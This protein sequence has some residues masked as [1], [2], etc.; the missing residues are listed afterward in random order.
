ME[1]ESVYLVNSGK[2][3]NEQHSYFPALGIISLGTAVQKY[4]PDIEL[5]VTDAQV[6]PLNE[7]KSS[8]KRK[9]PD[10]IGISVM[11]RGYENALKLVKE[12]K[13]INSEVILGNSYAASMGENILRNRPEVDYISTSSVGE[14]SFLGFLDY[15]EGRKNV[16]EVPKLLYRKNGKINHNP[17]TAFSWNDRWTALD[18]LPTPNRSLLSEREWDVFL[19]N[20]I[21]CY[22]R[23][24]DGPV[25]GVTTINRAK[26]CPNY[27]RRC[28]F[29][30]IEDLTL[31]FSSPEKFWEDVKRAKKQV[32]ANV[33]FE[34]CDGISSSSNWL[35]QVT[36]A[37]PEELENTSFWAY[38]NPLTIG[39]ETAK[40]LRELGMVR[41]IL[42][43]ESGN[44]KMLKRLKSGQA[45]IK[46][47]KKASLLLENQGID[48]YG[49]LVFGAPGET[50]ES[51]RDSIDFAYWCKD[52]RI[53]IEAQPLYP[54]YESRAREMLIEPGIAERNAE[55][56]GFEINNSQ[57][58]GQM[59]KK[60]RR[61][62]NP[63]MEEMTKDWLDIFCNVSWEDIM[64]AIEEVNS[65]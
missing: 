34:C 43:F 1:V 41:A 55:R 10:V 53:S 23:L 51:L 12:G 24:H 11:A 40:L 46:Q 62:D 32:D 28:L 13:E 19:N 54:G 4:R 58:L 56:E 37:K 48:A 64:E 17:E 52:H 61:E 42:G 25:T 63:D 18:Q 65:L 33:F 30:G 16:T 9:D 35:K 44:E 36:E 3:E 14:F 21:H 50:P 5:T 27:K 49:C 31:R 60:Y 15:L 2:D 20:Y 6:V 8:M 38:A 22:N 39:S 57:L 26:G 29:C 7:I 59:N 47:N 45:S